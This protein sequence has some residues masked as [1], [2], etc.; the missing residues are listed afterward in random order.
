MASDNPPF[1]A[2]FV[3]EVDIESERDEPL[4][5]SVTGPF[6]SREKAEHERDEQRNAWE[7][8]LD[9]WDNEDPYDFKGWDVVEKHISDH[10]I[11]RLERQDQ[12]SYEIMMD[13]ANAVGA[14]LL[15]DEGIGPMAEDD[16]K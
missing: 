7:R 9:E 12:E 6:A 15:A 3:I 11:D 4:Y 1:K 10:Q 14:S 13:A 16:T 2:W 5:A 8:A